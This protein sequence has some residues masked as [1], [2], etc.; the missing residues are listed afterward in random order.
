MQDTLAQAFDHGFRLDLLLQGIN[1]DN[2]TY[3]LVFA[4]RNS[5]SLNQKADRALKLK[6]LGA[7]STT[8]FE[9]AGLDPDKE[10]KNRKHEMDSGDPYPS[11]DV[12]LDNPQNITV[13]EGNGRNGESQTAVSNA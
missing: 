12:D 8:V 2:F 7:S 13:V 9:A 6:A 10:L 4:E 1:P 11:Q 3:D 5:E